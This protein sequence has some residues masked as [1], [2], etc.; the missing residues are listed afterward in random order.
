MLHVRS[1]DSENL[2]DTDF[3]VPVRKEACVLGVQLSANLSRDA[4]VEKVC[5]KAGKGLHILRLLRYHL[6]SSDLHAVYNAVVRSVMEYCSPAFVKLNAKLSRRLQLVDNRAH[7]I[8]YGEERKC[9]CT[10]DV[11]A[12]RRE[13]IARKQMQRLLLDPE[14]NLSSRLPVRL[15][16]SNRLNNFYCRTD[17]RKNSFFPY[18][19]LLLNGASM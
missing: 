13:Q 4:H 19:T 7:R 18:V 10:R 17:I 2:F 5:R 1:N 14:H 16:Y 6:T 12:T 3:G 8:I 11:L 9:S 15:A